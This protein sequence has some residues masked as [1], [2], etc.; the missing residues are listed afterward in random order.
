MAEN[1]HKQPA[2]L[3]DLIGPEYAVISRHHGMSLEEALAQVDELHNGDPELK[4]LYR[5]LYNAH[6]KPS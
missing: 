5:H 2:S 1:T 4:K 3:R 6:K